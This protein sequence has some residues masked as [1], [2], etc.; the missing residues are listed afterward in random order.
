LDLS[1]LRDH[2]TPL[3]AFEGGYGGTPIA[4][5]VRFTEIAITRR[6][7]VRKKIEACRVDSA[8]PHT[9]AR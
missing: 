9:L 3:S 4:P 8:S 5:A 7:E 1:P 2:D 6:Y